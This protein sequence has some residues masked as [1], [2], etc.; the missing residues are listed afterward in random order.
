MRGIVNGVRSIG[1][2]LQQHIWTECFTHCAYAINIKTW[3]NFQFDAHVPICAIFS[4]H[5]QQIV[6][7]WLNSHRHSRCNFCLCC[8]EKRCE[9]HVG[10]AQLIVQQCCFD[11][12]LSHEVAANDRRLLHKFFRSC[13]RRHHFD[14]ITL[15]CLFATV[16]IFRRVQ[17]CGHCNALSPTLFVVTHNVHIQQV[18]IYFCCKRCAKRRHQ[19][20]VSAH[21]FNSAD[22]D[23]SPAQDI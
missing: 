6:N 1:I 3:L 21:D 16:Y 8:T 20:D 22:H 19:V 12:C 9:R 4:N 5:S 13:C 23:L 11:S 7:R 10:F 2:H 17:R 14:Q 18:S 15:H